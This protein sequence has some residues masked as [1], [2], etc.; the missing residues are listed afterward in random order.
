MLLIGI[1][2]T[3]SRLGRCTTHLAYRIV[4]F[5][6]SNGYELGEYPF[7]ARLNPNIPWKTR[8][9]GAVCISV[10]VDMGSR[11]GERIIGAIKEMVASN[12]MIG[13]GANPGVV[14]LETHRYEPV[15]R[16]ARDAL[17]R[18]VS[19]KGALQ[20]AD[21]YREH[22]DG[23]EYIAMG[24]GQGIVGA[25]AS[26]GMA[27]AGLEDYTFEVIA[28]R[29]DGMCGQPRC[30][31]EA[32]VIAMDK[33]TH[34]YTFNN[35]DYKHA[36]VLIAPHGPDPVLLG[37]RGDDPGT[38]LD[39]LS[40]L[41]VREPMD[42]YMLFR[43]NQGTNAHLANMLD[44]SNLKAYTSGYVRG[45][46]ASEPMAMKGGH[47]FF[48]LE[49]DGMGDGDGRVLCA[50][51]EPT[52]L[53]PLAQMLGKG[54]LL[55]VGGGVRKGTSKHPKVLNVEYIRVIDVARRVRYMNPI[56]VCGKR[57]KS[58]GRGKGYG[59]KH[60]GYRVRD[61]ERVEVEV[62]RGVEPG[63]YIPDMKAHRHLT[64]PLHRYGMRPGRMRMDL[65]W[66]RRHTGVGTDH[67]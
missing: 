51:Y 61:A 23:I 63:L 10:K 35:Y 32:S 40:M 3:D 8:G 42:G 54:D 26:I 12:S 60:C 46:V 11:D 22:G 19:P 47:T 30:I 1:D 16:F 31:D 34:P 53:S 9:N 43:S 38:L 50:V 15:I 44:A 65:G 41:K 29:M 56:C 57:L 25:L 33:A 6:L 58:E 13:Y 24:N 7:L 55:E 62:G 2:D 28:Y 64:K 20:V 5:L 4:D 39:A 37:V 52:G 27:V 49:C 67:G 21:A 45:T 14:F 18:V 66:F 36:R 17:W 59:C 48:A